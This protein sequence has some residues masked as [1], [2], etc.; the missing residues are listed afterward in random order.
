MKIS[1]RFPRELIKVRGGGG[2]MDGRWIGIGLEI[3]EIDCV[4]PGRTR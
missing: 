3:C 2:A 1:I 4:G